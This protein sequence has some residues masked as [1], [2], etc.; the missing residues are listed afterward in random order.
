M[1]FWVK[2]GCDH[3]AVDP[4]SL[5]RGRCF[6]LSQGGW[7]VVALGEDWGRL[8]LRVRSEPA[9]A[10][11]TLTPLTWNELSATPHPAPRLPV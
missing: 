10:T 5:G 4:M 8:A 11:P 9:G 1:R 2:S 6:G 3:V 7:T